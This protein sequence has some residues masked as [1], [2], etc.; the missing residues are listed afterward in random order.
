MM[1]R[2]L[3]FDLC[4]EHSNLYIYS[5]DPTEFYVWTNLQNAADIFDF[6]VHNAYCRHSCSTSR[7]LHLQ[8]TSS[9]LR[10]EYRDSVLTSGCFTFSCPANLRA[11][12]RLLNPNQQQQ[13][14]RLVFTVSIQSNLTG[15]RAQ[16]EYTKYLN[17]RLV[18]SQLPT[19]LTSVVIEAMSSE[20]YLAAARWK[21]PPWGSTPG[22]R[23]FHENFT[24]VEYELLIT[25]AICKGVK[26]SAP[27]AKLRVILSD[28]GD[29]A[30]F[31]AIFNA[32]V[33]EHEQKW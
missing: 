15:P 33:A 16:Y 2:L 10:N 28:F 22:Q 12:L 9:N 6:R 18:C 31:A 32:V 25:D 19:T 11:F 26:K 13:L 1:Y 14:R 5:R 29:D 20:I 3:Q 8:Q 4:S 30:C 7:S 27:N 21:Y 23:S 24:Y 17:W